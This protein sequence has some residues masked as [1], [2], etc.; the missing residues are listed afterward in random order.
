MTDNLNSLNDLIRVTQDFCERRDWDH[1]HAPE[2]LAI[3]ITTEAA[4]LLSLFRFKTPEQIQTI[5]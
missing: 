2:Q 5:I 3:G 1:F 4:E